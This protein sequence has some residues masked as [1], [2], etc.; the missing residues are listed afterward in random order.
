M[1]KSEELQKIIKA[2]ESVNSNIELEVVLDKI[3]SVATEL[4]NSERGTLYLVDKDK[5]EL[6]SMIATGTVPQEIRLKIGEGLA[7][8][9]A[10]TGE[11]INIKNVQK[12]KRF[13]SDVDKKS[14]FKTK[15]MICFPIKNSAQ[16][17]IGVLQLL[18]SR[19]GEFSNRDESFLE[20]LSIHSAIAV[21]NALMHQKQIVINEELKQAYKDLEKAKSEADKF[22]MLKTHFLAQMS[23]EVRTPLNFILNGAQLLKINFNNLRSEDL[24][25]L[26][27][28]IEKG[29]N[30]IMR[31]MDEIIEMSK[32]RSG[33]YELEFEEFSLEEEILDPIIDEYKVIAEKKNLKLEYSNTGG[34]SV[35][36]KDRFMINQIFKEIIDNAVR[37][38]EFG[39]I[40]VA[41][42]LNEDGKL[43][44]SIQDTGIGISPDYMEV[45]FEPFTQEQ[46]G[47]TRK[48]EGNGLALA[49]AH[50]YA[51]LNGLS[52]SVNS[53]KNV[54]TEFVIVFN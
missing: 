35:V 22:V 52:I 42:S 20:A 48:Y 18:N 10:E 8:H 38:T 16:E 12:D 37:F 25:D 11:T 50:K 19:N 28:M 41:Q 6:W 33:N 53:E 30:R 23:H 26:F 27:S 54:G 7:G 34:K 21:H 17:I 9:V 5:H 36:K 15:N 44:V 1:L 46:T 14:G 39:M 2:A 47:Y 40:K 3:V 32:I 31:T 13:K 43:S 45:L 24:N 51:E 49:L 4:T 29:C